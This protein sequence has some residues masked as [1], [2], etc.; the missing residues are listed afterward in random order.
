MDVHAA[1]EVRRTALLRAQEHDLDLAAVSRRTVK[2]IFDEV[3]P[4]SVVARLALRA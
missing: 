4:V 2:M 3:F 1:L